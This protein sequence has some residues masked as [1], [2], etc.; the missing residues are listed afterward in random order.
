MPEIKDIRIGVIGLGYVGLPLARLFSTKYPTVGFDISK[1]R[2][3]ELKAGHDSRL[4]VTDDLLAQALNDNGLILTSEIEDLRECNFYVVAV[5]TPIDEKMLPDLRPILGAS[6]L[7]GKV[8]SK[9]DVVVFES[10]VYPGVTEEECMPVIEN[11]SGLK[12]NEDFFGGYSPER[13]NPGDRLHTVERILKVTSGSTPDTAELVDRVYGGVILSGTHKASSIKVAEASK[14]I[15]NAQRDVNIAFFNELARIF[16]AIGIDTQSVI[17]AAATKWNF[18][19]LKPG[20][21]GGH[22]I[23]VDPYYLIEKAKHY[24][25]S[26]DL[27]ITA[28][29]INEGMGAYVTAK[30]IDLMNR[31][32]LMVKDADV[33]ILGVTFKENCPDVR[34]TKVVS[35]YNTFKEYTDNITVLDYWAD[36]ETVGNAYGITLSKD[37]LDNLKGKFDAVIL[38]VSH[39]QFSNFN[40]RELLK[41]PVK[42][43]VYDVK[44][45]L[46]I[47]MV[48]GRL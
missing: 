19:K 5:P 2:V 22:C 9:G 42:G 17:D 1:A 46:P 13:I 10:T 3:D 14:V 39:C 21:V 48:D 28:R 37:S 31:K 33:L 24:D 20:L 8:I 25:I 44:S 36:A 35:I 38:A 41:D 40:V 7:I 27:L 11:T 32:G 18:I 43:V 34:N 30:T 12:Y 45:I 16:N 29:T 6:E 47:E 26:A 23:S 4:E 15:E